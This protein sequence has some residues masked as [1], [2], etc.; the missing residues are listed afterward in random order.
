M[1]SNILRSI[2]LTED[3]RC[4]FSIWESDRPNRQIKSDDLGH[5]ILKSDFIPLDFAT[6]SNCIKRPDQFVT[7]KS[8]NLKVRI[9]SHKKHL[10]WCQNMA[11]PGWCRPK[12]TEVSGTG[13]D[14]V[15]IPVPTPVLTSIPVPGWPVLM[16]YR[17]YQSIR[18]RYWCTERTEVSGT[19]I[20]AVPN[21]PKCSKPVLMLYRSYRSVWYRYWCCTDLSEVSGIGIDVVP[22]LPKCLVPVWKSVSVPAVPVS[23]SYRNYRSIRYR[24]WCR[25]EVI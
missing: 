10:F 17:A 15:P 12:L 25:T 4:H 20:D 7:S 22:S 14:V 13:I 21:L 19:G 11:V 2:Y 9:G 16:S 1:L 3:D 23:I 24:Y 18:Y 8:T 5:R 6:M